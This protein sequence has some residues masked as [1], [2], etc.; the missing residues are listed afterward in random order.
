M[1]SGAPALTHAWS[2]PPKY[3]C[4]PTSPSL[5]GG[6]GAVRTWSRAAAN[7]VCKHHP[8]MPPCTACSEA[9][10]VSLSVSNSLDPL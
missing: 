7:Q 10:T 6:S 8:V 5:P 1:A 3:P 2:T 4:T 9:A